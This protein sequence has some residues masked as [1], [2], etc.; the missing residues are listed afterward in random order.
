MPSGKL[1]GLATVL[2][3]A[4]VVLISGVGFVRCALGNT[5]PPSLNL[6]AEQ[7]PYGPGSSW[8][9]GHQLYVEGSIK[10]ALPFLHLAYRSD[11][12]VPVIALEFQAALQAQGYF[13]DALGVF[14]SLVTDFP[15]SMSYRFERS[16]L[17]A[18]LG[19]TKIA[20]KDL[21]VLRQQEG[22]TAEMVSLEASILSGSGQVEKA[23]AVLRDGLDLF[24][25]RG[26]AIYLGMATVLQQNKRIQDVPL[27]LVEGVNKFPDNPDLRLELIRSWAGLKNH[28]EA[29][30]A[31]TAADRYFQLPQIKGVNAHSVQKDSTFNMSPVKTSLPGSFR[32]ELADFYAQHGDVMLATDLLQD[33]AAQGELDLEP[34]LWLARMLLGNNQLEAGS[35]LVTDIIEQ[36][37][38]SGR[39]WFLKG[40]IAEHNEDRPQVL[41]AFRKAVELAPHDP[42]IRL[43]LVRTMLIEGEGRL[44]NADPD[45]ADVAFKD[46]FRH[47]V[48]V[49]TTMISKADY[50]GQLVLG[51]AFR[52]LED[53]DTAAWH[54]QLAAEDPELRMNALLQ[55]SLSMDEAGNVAKARSILE[56]LR[57]ENPDNPEIAN[58]LGYFL[59]EKDQELPEA[60]RLV[61]EALDTDRSNGAYL[62]SMGWV[63]YRLGELDSALDYLVQ[64]VNALPEDPVIL[65]HLGVVLAEQGRVEEAKDLFHRAMLLGGDHTRLQGRLRALEQT[66]SH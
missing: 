40:K 8:A 16:K 38:Q 22:V 11:P 36:W 6:T 55:A 1:R 19:K 65:E 29:L 23:M 9:V 41:A 21:D 15:D 62:D 27:I 58:S 44:D 32:V 37:P 60:K 47:E 57:K 13:D 31:A 14:D 12:K 42:E 63:M 26:A 5:E 33:L 49:A 7:V 20:L 39:G 53:M 50:S 25:T 61:Q 28:T 10:D 17:E 54:F 56:T 51:F 66:Q 2:F 3:S 35:A 59:A 18:R 48:S 43:N 64:A 45:S 34:S 46:E 30:A 24:P 52:L 4:A